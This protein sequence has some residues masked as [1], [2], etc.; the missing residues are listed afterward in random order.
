MTH[1]DTTWRVGELAAATGVSVRTLRHYDEVGLL[2]PSARVGD[3]VRRYTPTDV[4]RL[5]HILA[6]RGLG[7][8]LVDIAA[9]IDNSGMD[10]VDLLTR[11]LLEVEQRLASQQRLRRVLRAVLAT[12]PDAAA[13]GPEP[14][15]LIE[16]IQEMTDIM[17]RLTPEQR[18]ELEQG[19]RRMVA[20]LPEA[21]FIELCGRRRR[22]MA[23]LSPKD[24]T[25][26]RERR[27]AMMPDDE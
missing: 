24:Y 16:K 26:L 5:H 12:L 15:V 17:T 25:A 13:A 1:G 21:E 20:E 27:A 22:A 10:V 8:A 23:Q 3:G 4:Q 6:L 9:V 7:L 14:A 19:R 11:Q 18:H 2:T